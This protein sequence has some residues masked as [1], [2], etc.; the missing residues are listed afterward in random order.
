[1]KQWIY[2]WPYTDSIWSPSMLRDPVCAVSTVPV[3]AR[4]SS[5]HYDFLPQ[6]TDVQF[7]CPLLYGCVGH[8]ARLASHLGSPPHREASWVGCQALQSQA[9]MKESCNLKL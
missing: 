1:M 9:W 8:W 6:F 2:Q 3:F 7:I 4:L 5:G